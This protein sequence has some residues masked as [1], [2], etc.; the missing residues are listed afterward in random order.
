VIKIVFLFLM[1]FG[2]LMVYMRVLKRADRRKLHR[3]IRSALV[4]TL[5]AILAVSS[6]LFY[7]FNS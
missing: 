6:F 5:I 1:I 4:P 3:V 7:A 2:A